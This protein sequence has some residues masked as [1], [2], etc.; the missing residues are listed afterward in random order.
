[1]FEE[2]WL[3]NYSMILPPLAHM[4]YHGVGRISKGDLYRAGSILPSSWLALLSKL[5]A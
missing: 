5:S 2:S 3:Q 1:M 4:W